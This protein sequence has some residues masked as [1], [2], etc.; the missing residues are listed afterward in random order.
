M[1][2]PKSKTAK[3]RRTFKIS[4]VVDRAPVEFSP[5]MG[6]GVL[7]SEEVTFNLPAATYDSPLFAASL[8]EHQQRLRDDVIRLHAVEVAPAPVSRKAKDA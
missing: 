4:V 1:A 2:E 7:A 6:V 8:R 3:V 5:G